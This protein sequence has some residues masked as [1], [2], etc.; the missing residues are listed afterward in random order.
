MRMGVVDPITAGI[1]VGIP[2]V[3]SLVDT[4]AGVW[5]ASAQTSEFNKAVREQRRA[6]QEMQEQRLM[7]EA[8][9]QALASQQMALELSKQ[10]REEQQMTLLMIGGAATVI[11][12]YFIYSAVRRKRQA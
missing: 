3:S 2:I 11:A 10:R 9:M 1:T 5:G 8:K 12:G 6:Q 4:V 7:Q